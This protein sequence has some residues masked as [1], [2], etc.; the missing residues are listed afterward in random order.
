MVLA[1]YPR[2]AG[3][4]EKRQL[5]KSYGAHLVDMEG[6]AVARAAEVHG[7]QFLAVKAISD[8][9]N[10]EIA[11]LNRFVRSGGMSTGR[12]ILYL[13]PRPWLWPKMI[14]LARNTRLASEN[15]CAR[16]RESGLTHTMV[17]G[18]RAGTVENGRAPQA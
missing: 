13:V 10:F 12:L 1:S 9:L 5:G 11:G 16:L 7:L 6:A 17:A 4:A 18:T 15:L 3:C 14:R 2:I 8:D